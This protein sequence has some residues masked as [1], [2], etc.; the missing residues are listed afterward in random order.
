MSR[1]TWPEKDPAE[2]IFLGF[3]YAAD[4]DTAETLSGSPTVTASLI[5]GTDP[6]PSALLSGSPSVVGAVVLQR[7]VGGVAGASYTL[8]C[9]ITTS[10]S[11]VLVLAATL[12]VR[13]A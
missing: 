12:P 3:D 6:T 2:A 9:Q 10:A 11:R 13:T 5:A 7:V 8:R 4:L 1:Y